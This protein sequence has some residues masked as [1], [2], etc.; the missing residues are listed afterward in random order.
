MSNLNTELNTT[1]RDPSVRM[2]NTNQSFNIGH[3]KTQ[4]P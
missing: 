2:N 4:S 3:G 1:Q